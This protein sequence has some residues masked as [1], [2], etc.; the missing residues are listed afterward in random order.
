MKLDNIDYYSSEKLQKL[1][2]ERFGQ[3][4][5]LADME[6]TTLDM[7]KESVQQSIKSFESA[8]AFNS[9]ST[10]PKY[11]E[12]KLLVDAIV[13]E[14]EMRVKSVQGDQIEIEDP[15]KPGVTTTVDTKAVDVDTDE[16][17]NVLVKP[18]D[19]NQSNQPN[20]VK[21]GQKVSMEDQNDDAEA[22]QKYLMSKGY[23][24]TGGGGNEN[25]TSITYKDRDGNE[26]EVDIKAVKGM[27]EREGD[28]DDVVAPEFKKLV[29]DMQKG[30]SK[31]A[32]EKK[33][34]KRAQEIEQLA[35]DLATVVENIRLG[36]TGQLS[37][38]N[39]TLGGREQAAL[40]LMVG[41]QNFSLAKRA[42][43]MA[44][45][46]QSIP[47]ALMKGFMPIIDKLDTFIKGGASAVTRFS[48]LEKIVG[49]NESNEYAKHIQSLLENEMET[50]EILLAS[51]DVVD[52]ITDMYEK[53]AELKSSAVLELV[54]RMSNEVGQEKAQEYSN[55][56]NPALEALEDAL[57]TARE[58]A[59]NSVAV[60]KG[61]SV[62]PMVSTG[63]D[64][65]DN[66]IDMDADIEGDADIEDDFG[67]SEPAAGGDEPLGRAER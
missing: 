3:D 57:Q 19:N 45:S 49:R 23:T 9:N 63:D 1:I 62:E 58:S 27:G 6:L 35:K 54:D 18:K 64:D 39:Y 47:A 36:V 43:E 37:E 40:R 21:V 51:Q 30:M 34:P 4:I 15:K 12:N 66:D 44:K 10:N 60:V 28:L 13:K 55:V 38:A 50:S 24:I 59:Q 41:N 29:L 48:N 26:F 65:I 42:L 56:I 67:A 25:T 61:E 31:D 22:F 33:Y 46:G 11:V 2:A 8:M 20:K 52:Q 17:G 7:F 14:Q 5:S 16:Q 32:L 53:I